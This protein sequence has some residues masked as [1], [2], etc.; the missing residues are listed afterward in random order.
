M[1]LVELHN[2]GV[3]SIV[4]DDFEVT[5]GGLLDNGLINWWNGHL[6][7]V[8]RWVSV[9]HNKVSWLVLGTEWLDLGKV[10]RWVSINDGKISWLV[11]LGKWLDLSK[12]DRWVSVGNN[13]VAW[14]VFFTKW[15]DLG[16][17]D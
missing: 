1:L 12:V 7:E 3:N 10:N 15:L 13:K 14:L 2:G 5:W 17:V 8:N 6:S 16:E 9:G 4:V 11:L